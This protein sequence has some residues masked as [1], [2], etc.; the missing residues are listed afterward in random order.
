M[1]ARAHYVNGPRNWG[2]AFR[3]TIDPHGHSGLPNTDRIT[4]AIP[5]G[6]YRS[7]GMGWRIA[8]LQFGY[9]SLRGM[10]RKGYWFASLERW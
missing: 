9:Q 8:R 3:L 6:I 10:K 1:K 4:V 7:C 2:Q 5:C